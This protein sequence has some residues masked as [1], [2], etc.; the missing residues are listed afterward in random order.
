VKQRHDDDAVNLCLRCRARTRERAAKV[1]ERGHQGTS[2][3]SV[4]LWRGV[5]TYRQENGLK[6]IALPFFCAKKKHRDTMNAPLKKQSQVDLCVCSFPCCGA[7][8][9]RLFKKLDPRHG[10]ARRAHAPSIGAPPAGDHRALVN[11]RVQDPL[12]LDGASLLHN[13][14]QPAPEGVVKAAKHGVRELRA[15]PE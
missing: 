4:G 1:D 7:G 14:G 2:A 15:A 6:I 10:D 12:A 13:L 11:V 9:V 3:P 5:T 8:G